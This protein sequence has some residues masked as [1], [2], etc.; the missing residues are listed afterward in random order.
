MYIGVVYFECEY[1][2]SR[3]LLNVGLGLVIGW[4]NDEIFVWIVWDVVYFR[5]KSV[6]GIIWSIFV[7]L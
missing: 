6:G 5:I 4:G 7:Y 3:I 2:F 1:V